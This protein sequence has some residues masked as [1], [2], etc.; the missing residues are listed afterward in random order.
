MSERTQS[1][2]GLSITHPSL[3]DGERF[4]ANWSVCLETLV[5]E[6]ASS[7]IPAARIRRQI[8]QCEVYLEVRANWESIDPAKRLDAWKRLLVAAE[9]ACRTVLPVCIRCGQCCRMGSPTLHVEDLPLLKEGKIP[10]EKLIALRK[11]EPARSPFDGKAFVLSEE[12][13]KIAEKDGSRE[14]VFLLSEANRCSIYSD[15][16]LQCRAQ[17]CWDPIPARDT[18]ELPFLHRKHIFEGIGLLLDVIAEHESRCGFHALSQAFEQLGASGG[19]NVEQ[20][21]SL[22]SYEDHFRTFVSEKFQIPPHYLE[23]LLGRSFAR[24]APIFGFQVLEEADGTRRLVPDTP[25]A[26]D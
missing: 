25:E 13:I 7:L 2:S 18:A 21:L 16:P 22:F 20:V 8:E 6:E 3:W 15:R 4:E 10:W 19:E 9:Q 14:C 23:L 1:P 11:G 17:G 24:M 5:K 12:R 26:Q